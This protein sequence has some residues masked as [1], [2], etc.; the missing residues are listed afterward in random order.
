M[1]QRIN[2]MAAVFIAS[3][4]ALSGLGVAYAAW[5]DTITIDGTVTTGTLKWE[6]EQPISHADFG[7]DWNCF[8][9]LN[10][11]TWVQM[12]K[13][14][15]STTVELEPGEHPHVM[16]LTFDNAYPYYA[17]HIS[18]AVHS[19]GSIPLRIWK[20]NFIVDGTTIE[21]IYAPDQYVYLDLDDDGEDDFEIWWGNSFG[22]QLH[23]CDSRDISFKILVLQPA[24]QNSQ[25]TFDIELVGIQWNEYVAGPI[26][27]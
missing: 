25:L 18:F 20:V 17:N 14:V 19:Y 2:K 23:F 11:G 5:T 24:P 1:K 16:T 27:P 3:I 12:D 13:D 6:L 4:F 15:G 26:I 10:G 7:L 22:E 21:T 9:D 8:F